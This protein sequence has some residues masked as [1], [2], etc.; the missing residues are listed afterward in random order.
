M[1]K[2]SNEPVISVQQDPAQLI[3]KYQKEIKHLKQELSM[4][5]TLA[6]RTK[7]QYEPY[8]PE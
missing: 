6:N 4:K 7:I 5:N 8:T 3:K 1:M 2:V